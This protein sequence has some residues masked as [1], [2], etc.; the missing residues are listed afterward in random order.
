L[1][2]LKQQDGVA[3]KNHTVFTFPSGGVNNEP[4]ELG[5]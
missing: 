3:K 4:L 5:V 1:Q 2:T